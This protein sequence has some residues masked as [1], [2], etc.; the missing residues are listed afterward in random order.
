MESNAEPNKE[1]K[2]DA[3]SLDDSMSASM[4]ENNSLDEKSI[5]NKTATPVKSVTS[6]NEKKPEI[7]RKTE[8]LLRRMLLQESLAEVPTG[9]EAMNP[10]LLTTLDGTKKINKYEKLNV[11]PPPP[12]PNS[13]EKHEEKIDKRNHS[14]EYTIDEQ[15]GIFELEINKSTKQDVSK[16][17]SMHCTYI[18]YE[19]TKKVFRYDEV[20]ISFSFDDKD[21]VHEIYFSYPFKG[22]TTKGLKIDD[23]IDKAIQIYGHPKVKTPSAATWDNLSVFL[24]EGIITTIKLREH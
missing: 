6:S 21:I 17:M 20:G 11:P 5:L 18:E 7:D 1:N 4:F 19:L 22:C 2:K 3:F 14:C 9:N 12:P 15:K 13:N 16:A 24:N 8:G 10:I 23:S